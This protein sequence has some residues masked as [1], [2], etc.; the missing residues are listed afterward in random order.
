[1]VYTNIKKAIFLDRPNRFIAHIDIDG[2]V[3]VS[4]VKNTGRCRELF[5]P[6]ATVFVQEVMNEM[7]K[8]KYDLI[9]VVKEDR[10]I[11]VDSQVPNRVF[12]E[13]L[14]RGDFLPDVEKIQSER[15]FLNSRFDFYLEYGG[16]KAFVEVKGV[17]LEKNGVVMFPD[18]PT[19]RGVKHINELME[20]KKGGY[21]AFVVFVVQMNG[22]QYFTPNEETHKAFADTLRVAREK[23]VHIAAIDCEVSENSIVP[24]R[25]VEVRL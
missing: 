16:K 11:N 5:I 4:H 23:G 25:G 20:C 19:E 22:V 12:Y 3:E 17:T 14:R 13:W 7:R 18:A 15:R 6:G 8:T 1:M 2:T 9:S 10:L 21:E 24:G